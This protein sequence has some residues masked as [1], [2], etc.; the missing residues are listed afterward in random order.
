MRIE[1]LDFYA[2]VPVFYILKQPTVI[3]LFHTT[4]PFTKV[5]V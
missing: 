4:F 1:Y 3:N 2:K 5:S